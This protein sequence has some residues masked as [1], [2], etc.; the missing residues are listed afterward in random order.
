[1]KSRL[2]EDAD[3]LA[4]RIFETLMHS[5]LTDVNTSPLTGFVELE[6]TTPS[7]RVIRSELWS[8]EEGNAPGWL[9]LSVEGD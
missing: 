5:T 3:Y 8:D 4:K 2:Q 7:G 6:F 9:Q 1:M